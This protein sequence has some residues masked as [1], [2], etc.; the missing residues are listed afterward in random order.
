MRNSCIAVRPLSGAGGAEISG[1]DVA[2]DLDAATISKIRAALNE[3]CVVFFRDQDLDVERHKAFARCFG[4][5]FVHPLL[6]ET[7]VDPEVVMVRREPGDTSYFGESWHADTTLC[8]EPPMGTILYG[9]D[10][11]PYGGDTLFANQYLAYETLSDGMK[12]MLGGL[13]AVHCHPGQANSQAADETQTVHPVVRTNPETGRK[14]LFVNE[15][16]TSRFDGMTEAESRPLL[17]FLFEHGNRP[18][19]TF[20]FRWRKGSIAFWD[21]RSTKH[22]AL[23]DTGPF[24]RLMRRIQISGD[25]PA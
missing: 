22:I 7:T 20:R 12:E 17:N 15:Y 13:G 21:N 1:T 8:A 14:M 19:F 23:G 9:I 18:E 2:R 25:R 24:R 3:Y 10:V 11:P 16:H 6:R 5:I 4:E